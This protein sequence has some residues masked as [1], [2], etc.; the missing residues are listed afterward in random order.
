MLIEFTETDVVTD[1]TPFSL[2]AQADEFA[3]AARVCQSVPQCIR[4]TVWGLDDNMSWRGV[5][6]AATLF[7]RNYTPKPAYVAVR[8]ALDAG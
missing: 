5:G 2:I 8:A 7:D 1:G 3:K 4:F 6:S